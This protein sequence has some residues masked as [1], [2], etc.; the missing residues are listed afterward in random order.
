MSIYSDTL[1]I[2]KPY[3]GPASKQFLDRQVGR[4]GTSADLVNAGQVA[5]L[6]KWC[7]ISAALV[8]GDVKAN[9]IKT[10]VL[11]LG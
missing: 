1:D 4:I 11:A 10:K 5:D 9:E 8:I 2:L 6:A 7:Q 3:I